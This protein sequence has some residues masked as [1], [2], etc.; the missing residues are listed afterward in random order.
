MPSMAEREKDCQQEPETPQSRYQELIVYY[1]QAYADGRNRNR[2]PNNLRPEEIT[3]EILYQLAI[4]M[5]EG[6]VGVT[7]TNIIESKI[8][9]PWFQNNSNQLSPLS[10]CANVSEGCSVLP[11]TST[12]ATST[13]A[14]EASASKS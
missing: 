3:T 10:S 2:F 5:N 14:G 4:Y 13:T 8:N 7:N 6:W 11:R 12:S 1:G 9:D